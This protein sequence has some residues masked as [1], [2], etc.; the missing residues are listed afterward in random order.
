MGAYRVGYKDKDTHWSN[1]A[2][3]PNQIRYFRESETD[4]AIFF[5]SRSL[6]GNSLGFVDSLRRD[7]FKYPALVPTMPWKDR[8]PPLSPKSLKATLLSKGIEL[9]WDKPDAASDGD[10]VVLCH[11]PLSSRRKSN[12]PRS[13]A[14][15]WNVL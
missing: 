10:R 15:H 14:H 6:R 13:E 9:T 4:G 12:G 8:I 2:E 1:P 11:L 7:F 3:I 5:S